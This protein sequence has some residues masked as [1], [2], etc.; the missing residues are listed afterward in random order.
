VAYPPTPIS[1]PPPPQTLQYFTMNI[2]FDPNLE[3][4]E[5]FS[6]EDFRPEMQRA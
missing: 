4:L 3:R 1:P 6:K 2:S 5:H